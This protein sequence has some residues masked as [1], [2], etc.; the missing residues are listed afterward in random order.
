MF[1]INHDFC[2][3]NAPLASLTLRERTPDLPPP[4]FADQF[5]SGTEVMALLGYRD[6]GSFWFFVR[7]R[8]VPHIVLNQR[9]IVFDRRA[10]NAWLARRAVGKHPDKIL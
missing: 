1:G 6:R 3:E 5:M 4:R 10:L 2:S 9:K 7:S 8:G